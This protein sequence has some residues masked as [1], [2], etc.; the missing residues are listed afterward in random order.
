MFMLG[1]APLFE[2]TNQRPVF[3]TDLFRTVRRY[4]P[5][6]SDQLPLFTPNIF[7]ATPGDGRSNKQATHGLAYLGQE[8]KGCDMYLSQRNTLGVPGSHMFCVNIRALLSAS[9]TLAWLDIF[10][11]H[12]KY[13]LINVHNALDQ[14]EGQIRGHWV[15]IPLI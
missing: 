2:S 6:P 3:M 11:R 15:G 10:I 12:T 5:H 4:L 7:Q 8:V 1:H 9:I 14:S 13:V